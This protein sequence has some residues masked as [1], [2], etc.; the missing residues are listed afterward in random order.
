MGFK[1]TTL[2]LNGPILSFTL[3]P[4]STTAANAGIATFI[5]IA[6]ATFPTQSP[7]NPATNTGSISYRWYDS[8]GPLSDGTNITGSAT[9]TL[10]LSNVV[11]P[12]DNGR[13]LYLKA[14]YT[15]SAYGISPITVGT[16][17]STGNAVNDPID[18]NSAVL[19]VYPSLSII[20]Q[21]TSKTISQTRTE[22][23]TVL[24]TATDG[25]AVSY[26]WYINGV[27]VS[28]GSNSISGSTFTVSGATTSTLSVSST[29]TGSYSVT[30]TITH[31]TAD[32]SPLTSSAATFTV[33]SAR[34]IVNVELTSSDG[35]NATLYSWNLFD[36]GSFSI[37]PSQVPQGNIMS[38]YAPESDID[39]YLDLTANS[40][41]DYGS[42]RGGQGGKSTIRLTLKKNEEYVITSI[43]QANDG[44]AIYFYKKSRLVAVVG[45]GGNAGTKGN[46]GAGGGIN[47]AGENGFGTGAGAGG[48]LYAAGTL[49]STGIFGSSLD[50][51]SVVKAGDSQAIAPNPGRV[52]P[53]PRGD[54]WY[55]I[56][57][58][59]CAD[60]GNIQ[61]YVPSGSVVRNSAVISRGFKM[62]YGI[63]NNSGKGLNGGGNG[64]N[65]GAGGA[66]GNGGG[67]GG[68]GSG[69]TDGSV[70]IVSTQLGGNTGSG[71]IVIRSAV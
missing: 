68:G 43:S 53:C 38:F 33:V 37:G 55:N 19:T 69:Y 49:P 21:P 35:G 62:G 16:A 32:N 15:P 66:G 58:S 2:D 17:R 57:I 30:A 9:T 60:L 18:S 29:A 20:T 63:R 1:Q 59:A 22:T 3:H 14:D 45:G 27:A 13:S 11:N 48:I 46:G 12:T 47:V 67:G 52:L 36:Q 28:N 24:G 23:F 26:Q 50:N 65:G 51:S 6:T 25:S 61:L 42:Y 8:N 71:K 54:Y 4:V 34:Q 10:T 39:V 70:T 56:G 64:G 40:G 41:T 44:S 7:T 31:P 5:G